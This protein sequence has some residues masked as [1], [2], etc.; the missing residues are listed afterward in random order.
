MTLPRKN[1]TCLALV[2]ALIVG[3]ILLRYLDPFFVRSLRLI[4]FDSYQRLHPQPYDP[5]LP[6]RIVDIDEDSLA[7]IGQW[8]WPRT[9]MAKLVRTLADEGA[10]SV[11]FDVLFAEPDRTSFEQVVK[12]LPAN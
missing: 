5:N 8:P 4:A 9:I 11:A 6:V 1:L 3:A 7:K 2:A 10:A 12:Q